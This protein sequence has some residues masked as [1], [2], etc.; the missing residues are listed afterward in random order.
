MKMRQP[1]TSLNSSNARIIVD[2][3][4]NISGGRV[5]DVAT[6]DGDFILMLKKT[7]QDYDSF[8]GIDISGKEIE[9]AK[10]NMG[11]AAEF[12]EMNAENIEFEDG[13]F[14]TVCMANSLPHLDNVGLVLGEMKRVLKA[15]GHF[16]LQ[17]MFCDG[18]QTEAQK[19]DIL[20]HN[21]K[22]DVDSVLGIPNRRTF[23]RN[24]IKDVI[25]KLSLRKSDIFES[26][27]YPK[28]LF[29]DDWIKCEDPKNDELV[30]S[31][32]EEIDKGLRRLSDQEQIKFQEEA[33]KI[34]E[35]I[36][37]WGTASASILFII[38]KK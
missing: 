18:E 37:E 20:S 35:R 12:I 10:K 22:A 15:D 27:R 36:R 25:T 38:G 13:Y 26:S 9:A 28:C 16:I 31:A 19:S 34:K 21:L 24:E 17:E 33:K 14:D 4:K 30:T 6:G 8:I 3:L 5:L 2:S 11:E 1:S 23:T 32:I 7:L 29:C